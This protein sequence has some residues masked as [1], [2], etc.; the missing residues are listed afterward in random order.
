MQHLQILDADDR[1][2][3]LFMVDQR[4]QLG[5]NQLRCSVSTIEVD[6][7]KLSADARK[8]KVAG[9]LFLKNPGLL[10]GAGCLAHAT[11]TDDGKILVAICNS[12]PNFA[13]NVLSFDDAVAA[14]Q[15]ALADPSPRS[16]ADYFST[17]KQGRELLVEMSPGFAPTALQFSAVRDGDREIEVL[18]GNGKGELAEYSYRFLRGDSYMLSLSSKRLFNP[19]DDV[20][21]FADS[22]I[23]AN[24]RERINIDANRSE[25]LSSTDIVQ[26]ESNQP[27]SPL[28]GPVHKSAIHQIRGIANQLYS[29]SETE[30]L[31][32]EFEDNRWLAKQRLFGQAGSLAA[33]GVARVDDQVELYTVSNLVEGTSEL[34]RWYP[35]TSIYDA[36]IR[37]GDF[38]QNNNRK[39]VAG[40]A[41]KKPGSQASAI[42]LDDGTIEYFSPKTGRLQIGR[43]ADANLSS[44][45]DAFSRDDLRNGKFAYFE[46]SQQLVM[47]SN[48]L[49]LLTWN[50]SDPDQTDPHRAVQAENIYRGASRNSSVFFSADSTGQNIVT[51][52][53]N[54][55][56]M[57]VLW[58]LRN[59]TEYVASE[60]GP[61][62]KTGT[63]NA[64]ALEVVV[65]P[66]I[67]P[68]GDVIAAVLRLRNSYQIQ[69]IRAAPTQNP[70]T[71]AIFDAEPKTNFR[72]VRFLNDRQLVVS[73][74]SVTSGLERAVELVSLK[75][76]DGGWRDERI[77][78]PDGIV[79]RFRQIF[80]ADVAEVKGELIFA[81]FGIEKP[82]PETDGSALVPDDADFQERT[83]NRQLIAWNAA[84][85]LLRRNMRYSRRIAPRLAGT[86]LL[87]MNADRS[88]G[89][90]TL[91]SIDLTDAKNKVHSIVL[92]S[93]RAAEPAK[94]WH[95]CG[96][97]HIVYGGDEWFCLVDRAD[98]RLERKF[99]FSLANPARK[100]EL[101]G[102]SLVIQHQDNSISL[103]K[104]ESIDDEKKMPQVRR[105]PGFYHYVSLSPAG[106]EIAVVKQID[107][108]VA[109]YKTDELLQQA[110]P[111]QPLAIA[112]EATGLTWI[113]GEALL[114]LGIDTDGLDCLATASVADT[115][116]DI[117]LWNP[118]NGNA[119]ALHP[120]S[121]VFPLAVAR[122]SRMKTFEFSAVSGSLAAIVWDADGNDR[123]DIWKYILNP[124][125]TVDEGESTISGQWILLEDKAV[126]TVE[127][128]HF[129]EVIDSEVASDQIAPRIVIGAE[130][131]GSKSF[132]LYA[133]EL[134]TRIR[135]EHLLDL[136]VAEKLQQVDQLVGA[137]FT[138]D[139][140]TL[141]T[142]TTEM[143]QVRLT[144]G[145]DQK[146]NDVNFSLRV[147][148]LQTEI[149]ETDFAQLEQLKKELQ[150]RQQELQPSAEL[151]ELAEQLFEKSQLLAEANAELN[152]M[153]QELDK[154]EAKSRLSLE[155][156]F[157]GDI[158]E[159]SDEIREIEGKKAALVSERSEN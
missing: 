13:L 112:R 91:E 24:R 104:L 20:Q 14:Q 137:Q 80:V 81:G 130:K 126:G 151:D 75:Y 100:V 57:L 77:P 11:K 61:F 72:S 49:G 50:R 55:R 37:L 63:R 73:E 106:S 159:I 110:Q 123:A 129:S 155:K 23:A 158:D 2:F 53:P 135:P 17:I 105:L 117:G 157:R 133:L 145:W 74:D 140:K 87:F 58:Q 92:D 29:I 35:E 26:F 56:N 6:G 98:H 90:S 1:G 18:V 19:S 31:A 48:S 116:I 99:K 7:N 108:Q 71:L 12:N 131:E 34:R 97:E 141:L 103:V 70:E 44:D 89:D 154:N 115:S 101:A 66:A 10:S 120:N 62:Q 124:K 47:Y 156:Q 43:P 109:I 67:S 149:G 4:A 40:A 32:W 152:V 42:A 79:K 86:T 76:S 65:E 143:A 95:P 127:S 122:S 147:R 83:Q 150:L 119:I 82:V 16:E 78:V 27:V 85:E 153:M 15:N 8:I 60:L 36:T 121:S 138:G 128:V 39:I 88:S 21:I 144:D 68:G 139:G 84:G 148:Q 64:A 146:K 113:R 69:L 54:R 107:N 38:R 45:L 134:G 59:G 102:E 52:H 33:L 3:Q 30:I 5:L 93:E 136:F 9:Q 125:T 41:D 114:N 132:K 28:R 25:V 22:K 51:S 142:M 46:D 96:S 111:A 118:N 94:R